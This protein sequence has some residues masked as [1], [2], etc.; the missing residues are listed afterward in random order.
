MLTRPLRRPDRG[1]SAVEFALVMPLFIMMVFGIIAFGVVFAQ[2]LALSN[3]AREAA[4][5]SVVEGRTCAQVIEAAQ[6]ASNTIGMTGTAVTVSVKRGTSVA[7]ATNVCSD[8]TK[9]P[10]DGATAGD[11][12]YVQLDFTSELI[13]PLVLV[14]DTY[15]LDG[16]GVFRCEYA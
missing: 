15:P 10:C 2:K 8:T 6:D 12:V 13:I 4:R 16:K 3:G 7:T 11:S 5:F 1:A 14:E 9:E